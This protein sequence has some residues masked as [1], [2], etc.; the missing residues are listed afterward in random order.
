MCLYVVMPFLNKVLKMHNLLLYYDNKKIQNVN[1]GNF[2]SNRFVF[3][4]KKRRHR[5]AVMQAFL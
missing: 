5:K 4:D 2:L 1:N 3:M